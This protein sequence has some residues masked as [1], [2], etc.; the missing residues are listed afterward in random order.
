MAWRRFWQ[1]KRRDEDLA[2]ELESY[3]AH[4]QDEKANAG[5][6][7]GEARSAARRKLGNITAIREEVYRMNTLALIDAL[8]RDVRYSL[9]QLRLNPGFTLTA[10]VSLALGIGSNAAIFSLFDQL[11]L[12][13]LPV[14]EPERLVLVDWIGSKA[15]TN[16]GSGNLMSYPLCRDLQEQGRFFDGV[17]CRHPTVSYISTG[18]QPEPLP[19]E[20]VSGSYFDVLGI[21][22]EMGR[23]IERADDSAPDSSP[24]VVI[25]HQYWK[26]KL[27]EAPDVVG[28]RLL[29]NRHPMTIIGV[30]PAT[31][32]G[33]DP[34]ENPVL[35]IP[36]SMNGQANR[37]SIPLLSRRA[38]WMHIFGRLKPGISAEQAKTGLQPWFRS[39]L[40][41]DLNDADFPRVTAEQRRAFLASTIDVNPAPEGRSDLR[42]RMKEPLWVLLA[43][44]LLLL[45]LACANVANLFLARGAARTGEVTTRLALGA[46]R[47]R[48]AGPLLSESMLIA[49]GGGALALLVAPY[50]SQLLLSFVSDTLSSRLDY[51]VF[52]FTFVVCVATGGLCGLI[53]AFQAGRIQLFTSLK[54]RSRTARLSV[55]LRKTLVVGQVAFTLILLIGVGLFVQTL[56]RLQAK[57]PGFATSS[58][59]M[60]RASPA[61]N[62]YSDVDAKRVMREL[63]QRLENTP[64]VES[65]AI[66]NTQ[67]L[68]G[69]TSSSGMTIQSDRRIVTDRAVHF[70]RVTPEFFATLGTRMVAG[71]NFTDLDLRDP[72]SAGNNDYRSIIVSESFARRYFGNRSPVGR[73]LGFGNLP[74]TRTNVEIIGVV[75]GFSRRTLRDDRDDIEQAFVPYWDRQSGG[76]AFYLRVRGE[77]A[78]AFASIRSVVAQVDPA[79]PI[80]DMITLDDQIARSL[81][82]ERMLAILSSGFGAI[83]LLLSVVGLYG[84][85]SF[86]AA[87]RTQEIG[88][89]MALGATRR[90]AVWLIAG[91]ALVMIGSGIAIALPCVWA[92]SRFV[93]ALLFGVRGVDVPT[94]AGASTLL[95]VVALASAM[96]PAWRAASISPTE[97]LRYE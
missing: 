96:L 33:V 72:K 24:V 30:A 6:S 76:G 16:W 60:F 37:E 75:K 47:I 64:G 21:R 90:S 17:F 13:R 84:V 46:S 2:R 54:E 27:G 31:F 67:I 38:Q 82:T 29:I 44:T 87:N 40:E 85:I 26:S 9:R 49:L 79:L 77:P 51:R 93:E 32:R 50:V 5:W 1:R 57:G 69:G 71:R 92:L 61:S 94:I 52:L 7:P 18:E 39:M 65:A 58:L 73:R 3:L 34:A 20:I 62:G 41:A 81:S 22:P 55:R 88:V 43:G 83:A 45:L 25:S 28:R 8:W 11:L 63:L 10:L 35:W 59:L 97:A 53:P 36:A 14:R 19:I 91:D 15:G 23:L 89:R 80:V 56:A 78:A 12:R 70:M 68:T 74:H 86:V 4:E 95:G 42:N 66:A 48:I